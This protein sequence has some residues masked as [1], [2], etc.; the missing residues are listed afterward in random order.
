MDKRKDRYSMLTM[1]DR[2]VIF[3]TIR[4]GA[5]KQKRIGGSSFV[6]DIGKENENKL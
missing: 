3:N 5:T 4:Q 1:K 2:D 6:P